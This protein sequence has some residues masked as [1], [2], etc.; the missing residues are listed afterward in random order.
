MDT[1]R[2]GSV[3]VC[4]IGVLLAGTQACGFLFSHAPPE[5]HEQMD[6]F[7]CTENNTGP[8][9]DVV[10]GSLNVI[11]AL[12]VASDPDYYESEGYDPGTAVAVGL[13]WG[14]VSGTAAVVGFN[15]SKK[16]RAAKQALAE[17]QA[18]ALPAAEQPTPSLDM[19]VH[20]V[21]ISP[22]SDTL[23]SIGAQVQLTATARNSAGVV[24]FNKAFRWSSSNDAI[25]SVSNAGLVT[26]HAPGTVAIAANTE[27]VVGTAEIV[28]APNEE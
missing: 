8:I 13:A 16:C 21:V 15:K 3:R 12:V 9:I 20:A 5:G 2:F 1:T 18:Q 26:A 10:W 17:R 27:N 24:V 11:G 28:V 25:A 6:Y 4:L 22:A 19:T 23:K 7:S 14:A